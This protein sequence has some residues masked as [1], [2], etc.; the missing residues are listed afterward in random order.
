MDLYNIP[1]DDGKKYRKQVFLNMLKPEKGYIDGATDYCMLVP[2]A[3]QFGLDTE[4]RLWLAFLYGLTYSQTT[5]MRVFMEFPE[6][7]RVKATQ[8]ERFWESEKP[9][10]YFSRDKMRIKNNNQFV[11]S[12]LSLKNNLRGSCFSR[13]YEECFDF[14]TL[15]KWIIRDWR[16]FGPHGAYL[17]FDAVYGLLPNQYIDP[18]AIDWKNCGKTVAQGMSHL[19]YIDEN[20]NK[21]ANEHDLNRYNSFV[22]KLQARSS[23]PKIVIESTLCAFKK[24]FKGSRYSGYYADRML[25]EITQAT[26]V[27]P[28]FWVDNNIDLYSYREKSVPDKLRGEIQGWSGIRPERMRDWLD[29]GVLQVER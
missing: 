29:K 27:K 5:S 18:D 20:S 22:D 28:E 1:N 19:L 16:F 10:L 15:Y 4:E 14:N 3:E 25:E 23:Q 12:V 13:K 2:F 7:R 26:Q 8:L 17:F 21:P 9:G 24:L 6:L 11:E